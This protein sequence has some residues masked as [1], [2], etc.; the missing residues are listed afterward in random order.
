MNHSEFDP[1]SSRAPDPSAYDPA[2]SEPVE[3]QAAT[4]EEVV[5]DTEIGCGE[6]PVCEV[7]RSQALVVQ[8]RARWFTPEQGEPLGM[9]TGEQL[10]TFR[11]LRT[12]LLAAAGSRGLS[13]FTILVVPLSAHSGA[14][15]VSRNLAASLTLHGDRVTVLVDCNL[16]NPSQHV[17]L[18]ARPTEGGLFEFLERPTMTLDRLVLPTV[19]PGLHLIPS[20]KPSIAAREYFSSFGMNMLLDALRQEL[21]CVVLDG[22]PVQGAPDARIL[23]ELADL[24]VLVVGYARSSPEEIEQAAGTFDR[25]KFAGVVFNEVG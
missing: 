25:N 1:V 7:D 16:R 17:A 6:E 21:C 20:G 22:P 2:T 3:S 24:V 11:E 4:V 14:S 10:D 13:S 12:R 18:R 19:I 15:F 8:P 23:S 9:A 5:D